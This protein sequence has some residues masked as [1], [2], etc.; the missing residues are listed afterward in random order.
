MFT[1][2]ALALTL[3]TTLGSAAGVAHA[4]PSVATVDRIRYCR[5]TIAPICNSKLMDE[6][7]PWDTRNVD[8]V[9]QRNTFI[10]RYVDPG[11]D[12][13]E[14]LVFLSAGQRLDAPFVGAQ[15]N[16]VTGQPDDF[17]RHWA[18]HEGQKEK[19]IDAESI[20]AR[21]FRQTVRTT[22]NTFAA[23]AFDAQFNWGRSKA[24]KHDVESAFYEWLRG[25]FR[26][27][28]IRSIYL[29]GHSRGGALVLRLAK[30]F[31]QEFPHVPVIVH[32]FDAVPKVD[33]GELMSTGAKIDNPVTD[34]SSFFTYTT[35]FNAYFPIK[36][37]LY[38]LN[39][40]SGDMVLREA[41]ERLAPVRA[42]S[43]VN[44]SGAQGLDTV[45]YR[46]VWYDLNHS[47]IASSWRTLDPALE[48]LRQVDGGARVFDNCGD[49]VCSANESPLTC[50]AD[51]GTCGNGV[52]D[53]TETCSSC[54]SECG[55]C[56]PPLPP[57]TC[58]KSCASLVQTFQQY[59]S[60]FGTT[61]TPAK[62]S[63]QING[64]NG[65]GGGGG[66]CVDE[67]GRTLATVGGPV[68]PWTSSE[69]TCK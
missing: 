20:A 7:K 42:V 46:Q 43:D 32:A 54:P 9:R 65:S 55:R 53:A 4:Q 33:Q 16:R 58:W 48:H 31:K 25:K 35:D 24:E 67:K 45:W 15:G 52:C 36:K 41:T 63:C 49:S 34:D 59:C 66:A 40:V 60:S 13:V 28:N 50:T 12:N 26:P 18:D 39:L 1:R 69:F 17:E 11:I 3:L 2:L 29:G 56:A 37:H 5:T 23:L 61:L 51:C 47:A 64:V 6:Y 22:G 44:A 19:S 30:R 10:S 62:M 21:I 27:E 57:E 68:I 38:V 14:H 8:E